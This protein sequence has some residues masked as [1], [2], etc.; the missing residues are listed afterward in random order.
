MQWS[1]GQK[2]HDF[3][4]KIADKDASYNIDVE[5][6]SLEDLDIQVVRYSAM[7]TE[8]ICNAV[9]SHKPLRMLS[10]APDKSRVHG[11]GLMSTPFALE[12]NSAFWG[13]PQDSPMPAIGY[14]IQ[15]MGWPFG[16]REP[17][18]PEYA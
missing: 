6:S 15:I 14:H 13:H 5:S 12:D 11:M 8:G 4:H 16:D 3:L 10:C 9:N 2:L 18:R 7:Y 17:C 1:A